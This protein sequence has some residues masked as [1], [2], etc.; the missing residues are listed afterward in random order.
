MEKPCIHSKFAS[1]HIDVQ[2]LSNQV[3]VV[4]LSR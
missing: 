3:G 2:V 4:D 1:H